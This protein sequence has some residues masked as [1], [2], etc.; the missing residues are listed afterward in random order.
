M[1]PQEKLFVNMPQA[2]EQYPKDSFRSIEGT[3]TRLDHGNRTVSITLPTG[4]TEELDFYA[5]VIATG[6]STP[7]SLHDLNRDVEHLS[8]SW[9]AFREALPKQRKSSSQVEDQQ[10]SKQPAS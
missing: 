6:A 1:F 7:F 9:A 5:L 2:F 3:A 4:N 8:K 10:V